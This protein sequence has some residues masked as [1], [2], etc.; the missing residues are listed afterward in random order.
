[1]DVAAF[2]DAIFSSTLPSA[3]QYD[4]LSGNA[5]GSGIDNYTAGN[6]KEAAREFRRTIALSPFS[7]NALKAFEYLANSFIKD[8]KTSEAIQTYRQ[9]IKVFP[10]ADGMNLSLG[11]LLYSEG[12]YDEAVEQ[13]KAAVTKNPNLSQN[14]YSLGQGYLSIDR[15]A[16]AEVQFKRS[17]QLSP[18]DS[19]GY[20]ALGQ[21]YRK[22]GRFADAQYELN[23]A[24]SIDKDLAEAHFELG[25]VYAELQ[26]TDEANAQ[27]DILSGQ[28]SL[29]YTELLA[30]IYETSKPK[31]IAAYSASLNL[32]SPAGTS[33]ST[34]D[35][36]LAAPGASKSYTMTFVFS[37]QMDAASVRSI[38]NWSISRSTGSRTGGL[39]NWGMEIPETEVRVS[40][41]PSS[42]TYD[43]ES[44]TARVTF[45][46]TQNDTGDGTIDLSHLVFKFRGSDEYGN[47]MDTSAD[48]YNRISRIV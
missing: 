2:A 47:V 9:A 24:L 34:I 36:S 14:V 22:M 35:P 46:I 44:L 17:I 23:R 21:N 40:S 48:E 4:S 32:A 33:L 30:K 5:L 39:Y 37:K 45:S 28:S 12:R 19:G 7:D 20:N 41:I 38:G 31:V 18:E 29:L 8:G 3:A 16:D 15:N 26:Q 10:S 1:M 43:P 27:L 11:N 13:Y 6:Y 42:V 25:L